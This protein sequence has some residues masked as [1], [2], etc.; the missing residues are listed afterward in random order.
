[1]ILWRAH[2]GSVRSRSWQFA[3]S[4]MRNHVRSVPH[5]KALLAIASM[6]ATPPRIG[7]ATRSMVRAAPPRCQRTAAPASPDVDPLATSAV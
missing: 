2:L 6:H 1:L 3:R 5:V 7:T 4:V